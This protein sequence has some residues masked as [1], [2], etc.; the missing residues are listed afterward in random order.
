MSSHRQTLI[1]AK[2][3]VVKLGTGLLTDT[4]NHLSP[5]Q[6][7]NL[8]AQFADLCHHNRQL[9]IVSSGAIGAG[10]DVLNL[11][12]RPQTLP[13]LQ[14]AAAIG[15]SKLMSVYDT[16]FARSNLIVAQVLLT[17][18]DL[19]NRNRHINARNTLQALL[20]RGII[21]IINENDTVSVDE[22][23]FGDNDTLS[24]L[25]ATLI[26]ADL[27]IILSHVQGLLRANQ[28]I[29]IVESITPDI[30]RLATGTNR[31]T[32]VG[33]MKSKIAAAKICAQAGIP[34]IIASGDQ[35][36]N[37]AG[38]L[39]G[40]NIGTLF[41]PNPKRM[42]SRKRWIAFFQRAAAIVTVDDGAKQALT[43]KGRS[44]LMRGVKSI[45]GDFN[46]SDVLSI[47]DTTGAE[48]ARG[49]ARANHAD[50]SNSNGIIVHRDDLVVL[51]PNPTTGNIT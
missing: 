36:G 45:Q 38:I 26:D 1:S 4:Q 11:T 43:S 32:S 6:I 42:P 3:I 13:Q 46:A 9:A 28:V 40:Q 39:D 30:E 12:Q 18:D 16:T 48:F 5:T 44:L 25:T 19:R 29:P 33:G 7:Q 15:Q 23:R 24:A 47:R 17:H 21:P 35:P 37:L 34:M 20:Q 49:L 2:R 31:V 41:V 22:I 50:C 14:A 51:Q 10:M 8:V 27:L